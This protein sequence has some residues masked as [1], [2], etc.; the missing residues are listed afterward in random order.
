MKPESKIMKAARMAKEDGYEYMT[1]VVKSVYNTTYYN[2]NKIDD[3]IKVGKWIP[4][5]YVSMMPT[6]DGTGS[7]HGRCGQNW[8]PEKSINKSSAI[9]KYCK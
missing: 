3:V 6:A 4:A 7:W 9:R 2:V 1:S 5:N 8:L